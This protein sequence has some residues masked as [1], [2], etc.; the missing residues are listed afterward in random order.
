[1]GFARTVCE[2]AKKNGMENW[3]TTAH[4]QHFFYH[5]N[6][7][8]TGQCGDVENR[9]SQNRHRADDHGRM[10]ME[11]F[12]A[13]QIIAES[14][15][16]HQGD[17]DSVNSMICCFPDA[18]ED[19]EDD[20]DPNLTFQH[21]LRTP[22]CYEIFKCK[23]LHQQRALGRFLNPVLCNA[24]VGAEFDRLGDEEAADLERERQLWAAVVRTNLN[25]RRHPAS[26]PEASSRGVRHGPL[27]PFATVPLN[28]ISSEVQITTTT[29]DG[30]FAMADARRRNPGDLPPRPVSV[31]QL[32]QHRDR[33]RAE[34]NTVHKEADKF[35]CQAC[36]LT[37]PTHEDMLFR[38]VVQPRNCK[39]V[40]GCFHSDDA[41]RFFT[42]TLR[43]LT[44]ITKVC[45]KSADLPAEDLLLGF[46]GFRPGSTDAFFVEHAF[47][48][49]C[50]GQ[51][52]HHEA[53]QVLIQLQCVTCDPAPLSPEACSGHDFRLVRLPF[54][55]QK[56]KWREPLG[57]QT[58]GRLLH[59]DEEEFAERIVEH[60][61]KDSG[62][63]G[64]VDVYKFN[65]DDIDLDLVRITGR[66]ADSP[67]RR[68]PT[69]VKQKTK[70][71]NVGDDLLDDVLH[72]DGDDDDAGEMHDAVARNPFL[73][74]LV[75]TTSVSKLDA[76]KEVLASLYV[77][78][79][80][81]ESTFPEDLLPSAAD[82]SAVNDF[83]TELGLN[84][85]GESLETVTEEHIEAELNKEHDLEADVDADVL[86][87]TEE[88]D[89]VFVEHRAPGF[90]DKI[91]VEGTFVTDRASGIQIG[92]LQQLNPYT[93]KASCQIRHDEGAGAPRRS[94]GLKC[95]IRMKNVNRV[96]ELEMAETEWLAK[97]SDVNRAE[98][99]RLLKAVQV[100]FKEVNNLPL[101]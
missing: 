1:M 59:S 25:R 77:E 12:T 9:H 65:F 64:N 41:V 19:G 90:I 22:T 73:Q 26:Q 81:D 32:Q 13:R 58:R 53:G 34:G 88:R 51:S 6:K 44:S 14:G 93:W 61:L 20:E 42:Q 98:H 40:C 11:A 18:D 57:R 28:C 82:A 96:S 76:Y 46:F 66:H 15:S 3:G 30:F 85:D 47:M 95:W 75:K 29:Y 62:A 24:E 5:A 35:R 74:N 89:A 86:D 21:W 17:L 4:G 56:K 16:L 23:Y 83:L 39:A 52:G 87:A 101:G 67:T 63:F 36:A 31:E 45:R 100:H 94:C 68:I 55:E 99:E 50:H 2:I 92:R 7:A 71:K 8:T 72:S 49:I 84:G 43:E 60:F 70:R 91:K 54:V 10:G 33:L 69:T 80:G 78:D 37:L 27:S 79:I 48:T 97:G 38:K